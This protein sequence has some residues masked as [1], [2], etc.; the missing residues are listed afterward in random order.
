MGHERFDKDVQLALLDDLLEVHLG[1]HDAVRGILVRVVQVG[2]ALVLGQGQIKQTGVVV[3]IK[4]MIE[5]CCSVHQFIFCNEQYK[6][7]HRKE[8]LD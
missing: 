3:Q 5:S 1:Q 4:M 6:K 8:Y 7:N 2:Q